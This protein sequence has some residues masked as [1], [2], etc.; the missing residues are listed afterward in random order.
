MTEQQTPQPSPRKL[1][2]AHMIAQAWKNP[3]YKQELLNNSKAV[4]EREF[5]VKL[6]AEVTVQVL[7]ESPNKLYFVIP[8]RP[9]E[10]DANLTE[11]QLEAVA[12]GGP[13]TALS[14]GVL[15]AATTHWVGGD[16]ADVVKNGLAGAAL[17]AS[18]PIP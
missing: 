8:N 10:A 12:G 2:E 5:G 16:G 4:I 15:G 1:I 14:G 11:E 6:P 3:A 17:T 13:W 9:Q 7:E 18:L